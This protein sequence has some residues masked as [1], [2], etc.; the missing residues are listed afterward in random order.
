MKKVIMILAL[1]VFGIAGVQAQEAIQQETTEISQ[2]AQDRVKIEA[3]S[4]P[5]VVRNTISENAETADLQITEAWE[6]RDQD[7]MVHYEV[8]FWKEDE[9]HTKKYDSEGKEID[10]MN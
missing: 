3:D 4:L 10:D 9:S 5:E 6:V 2:D 8:T 1:G 7:G